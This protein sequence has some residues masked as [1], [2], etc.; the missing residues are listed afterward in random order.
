M[1]TAYFRSSSEHKRRGAMTTPYLL[2]E[3]VAGAMRF[4]SKAFAFEKSGSAMSG[5]SGKLTHAA[6]RLGDDRIMMGYPGPKY[7]NP[8]KLGEGT[9]ILH[10][11]VN[12]AGDHFA[13]AKKAGAKIIEELED[14]FYG[15]RRYGAEEPEGHQWYF[16]REIEAR[17]PNK[18]R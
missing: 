7:K 8:K 13:R 11:K 17:K 1:R 5:K 4:L 16:F 9:Q 12:D 14:T 2:Y 15:H 6:M 10:V 3:D 18:H